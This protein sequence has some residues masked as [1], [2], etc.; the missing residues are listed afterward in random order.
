MELMFYQG[1]T[2]NEKHDMYTM[3]Q[4]DEGYGKEKKN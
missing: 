3:S 2:D 4:G 1:E